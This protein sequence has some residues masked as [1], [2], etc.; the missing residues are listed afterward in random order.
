[1]VQGPLRLV[2]WEETVRTKSVQSAASLLVNAPPEPST[3]D[4]KAEVQ[5][6]HRRLPLVDKVRGKLQTPASGP[7]VRDDTV[8]EK[9]L[10][11]D[12]GGVTGFR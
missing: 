10:N 12:L 2:E 3:I 8:W 11:I 7:F 1:L 6:K 4:T 5:V 9:L